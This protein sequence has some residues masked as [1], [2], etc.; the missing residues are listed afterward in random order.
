MLKKFHERIQI[1]ILTLT[2]LAVS[3]GILAAEGKS[4]VFAELDAPMANG[5]PDR[6]KDDQ[7]EGTKVC[8]PTAGTCY[9]SAKITG[10]VPESGTILVKLHYYSDGDD[11][12]TMG[13]GG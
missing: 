10:K 6:W 13:I 5:W 7:I 3:G 11:A 2:T 4:E 8:R 1:V 9:A 12:F